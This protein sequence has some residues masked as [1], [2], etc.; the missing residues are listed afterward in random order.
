MRQ[1]PVTTEVCALSD[2]T[3][4]IMAHSLTSPM[5]SATAKQLVSSVGVSQALQ[6]GF[7]VNVAFFLLQ[8]DC[9]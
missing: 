1:I 2:P 7:V 3:S 5:I 6:V 9:I 8:I 4:P